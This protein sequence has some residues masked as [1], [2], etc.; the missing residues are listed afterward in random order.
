MYYLEH[1][2]LARSGVD[3]NSTKDKEKFVIPLDVHLPTTNN[4]IVYDS[5]TVSIIENS[6]FVALFIKYGDQSGSHL[7]LQ[8][9]TLLTN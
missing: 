9:F 2:I 6:E 5:K 1:I 7:Q 8:Q 4:V 3:E